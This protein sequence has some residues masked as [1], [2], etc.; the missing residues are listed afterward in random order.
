MKKPAVPANEN[1]RLLALRSYEILDTEAEAIFDGITKLAVLIF[2]VPICLI[3]LI[4]ENRQWFK[5]RCGLSASETSRD[6][7]F[8]GHAINQTEIFYI[9]DATKDER[10]NDNPL[11]AG[12]PNIIFYAGNPLVDKNGYALGTLCIIDSKP[13]S[14]SKE[15]LLQLKLLG[16]QAV[17][18]IQSRIELKKKEEGRATIRKL[19]EMINQSSKMASLGEMASGVAHEINNPLAIIQSTAQLISSSLEQDK[20]DKDELVYSFNKISQ[21]TDRIAKIVRGLSFFSHSSQD[22]QF[23][24]ES[25][26]S[27]IKNTASLCLEKF[28]NGQVDFSLEYSPELDSVMVEC[29]AVEISQVLLNL[30]N[31]AFDAIEL[32]DEK[33]IKVEIENLENLVV[34]SI[35]DS[36]TGMTEEIG[37]KILEAF[38][39]TKPV[40]KGTGLGLSIAR[41]IVAAH[42]GKFWID[43]KSQ[44]TKF[45]FEIPKKVAF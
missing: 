3:S 8:C 33:W 24:S 20:L 41:K 35:I 22:D 4:D 42:R 5:S 23:Y 27:I 16:D 11:V 28:R 18:L 17:F 14:L 30:L 25:I 10:F 7:S 45:V 38:Y 1:E 26:L 40:G 13:R 19:E 21:T 6:A 44:N 32:F 34:F 12:A 31:N 15:Q 37:Q 29:R 39:T 2:E 9:E 36:G 43:F